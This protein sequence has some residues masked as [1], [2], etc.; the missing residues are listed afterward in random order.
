MKLI[1][2]EITLVDIDNL[3]QMAKKLK[4]NEK[5]TCQKE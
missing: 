4:E 1:N 5:D 2:E 3:I